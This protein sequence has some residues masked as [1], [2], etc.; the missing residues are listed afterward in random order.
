METKDLDIS[1][2]IVPEGYKVIIDPEFIEQERKAK[3]KKEL[4]DRLAET[5]EPTIEELAEFGRMYHPYYE[6]LRKLNEL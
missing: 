5:S 6:D 3:E 2:I 4:E 1:N